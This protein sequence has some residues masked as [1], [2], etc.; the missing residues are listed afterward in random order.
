MSAV[1]QPEG[2]IRCPDAGQLLMKRV[3]L[4]KRQQA[5]HVMTRDQE[6]GKIPDVS[7]CVMCPRGIEVAREAGA[8]IPPEWDPFADCDEPAG[9]SAETNPP[10]PETKAG[11]PEPIPANHETKEVPMPK[12]RKEIALTC[13][14]DGVCK[15][16]GVERRLFKNVMICGSCVRRGKSRHPKTPAPPLSTVVARTRHDVLEDHSLKTGPGKPGLLVLIPPELCEAL[17]A[18]ARE[19]RRTPED[20]AIWMV[21]TAIATRKPRIAIDP[22]ALVASLLANLP[23]PRKLGHPA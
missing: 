13:Y 4:L 10:Q 18:I 9:G 22:A 14:V 11:K 15:V 1:I 12:S 17:A 5:L 19:N 21:E 2:V 3:C 6:A 16:C 20:Q 23:M 8:T 7:P